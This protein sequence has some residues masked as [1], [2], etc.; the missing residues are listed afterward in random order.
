MSRKDYIYPAGDKIHC[1]IIG[2]K[3]LELLNQ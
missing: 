3:K 2:E 1:C